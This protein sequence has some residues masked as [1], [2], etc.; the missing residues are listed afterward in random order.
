MKI[1]CIWNLED[2]VIEKIVNSRSELKNAKFNGR[3]P[4]RMILPDTDLSKVKI[5]ELKAA[6]GH[7]GLIM[8]VPS[9]KVIYDG[10]KKKLL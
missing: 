2:K 4:D 7:S 3:K 9:G 8:A 1:M 5:K 6:I 10:R